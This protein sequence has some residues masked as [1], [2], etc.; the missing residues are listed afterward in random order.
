M[1]QSPLVLI[2]VLTS[3][4]I[5]GRAYIFT[6]TPAALAPIV[7]FIAEIAPGLKGK[8]V[9]PAAR[10]REFDRQFRLLGWQGLVGM[11]V[12]GIDMALW[13]ALARSL[14]QPA[15]VLLGASPEPLPAYDSFGIIDLA[16]DGAALAQSVE[17]GFEAIKI[18]IG[19]GDLQ[20]DLEIIRGVRSIIGANVRLMIDYNQSL[21][22]SEACRRL[23]R[24]TEHDIYW[25]EEPVKAE[26]LIGQARVRSASLLPIQSGENWWFP[27]D[28]ATAA[29][30]GA[31]DLA[32]LDLMKIGGI[33]G[34][35][36]A[37]GQAE[38]ASLPVSSHFFIEASAHVLAATPTRHWIEHLDIASAILSDPCVPTRGRIEAKGPGLGINWNE[39]AVARYT[40]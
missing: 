18:K 20:A 11:A 10:M 22:S 29:A 17:A 24:L 34:W 38:A 32:M 37:S 5:A 2:D 40:V 6:Y 23:A 8:A 9:A 39:A 27:A 3:A 21:D 16:A 36:S 19:G 25:V 15:A 4:G 28:L 12:S 13:D 31:T 35:M 30:M 33:T 26:D 14:D 1:P 7:R